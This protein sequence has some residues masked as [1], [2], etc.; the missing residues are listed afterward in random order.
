MSELQITDYLI[1]EG[2]V[3]MIQK[4]N[5]KLSLSEVYQ[6]FMEIVVKVQQENQLLTIR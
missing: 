5:P 2:V 3:E 6:K 4:V 1:K